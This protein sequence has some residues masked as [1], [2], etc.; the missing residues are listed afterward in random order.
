MGITRHRSLRAAALLLAAVCLPV[1]GADPDL[2]QSA[3][4]SLA[5]R[6]RCQMRMHEDAVEFQHC[7]DAL[8]SPAPAAMNRAQRYARLGTAYYA[9]LAATSAAKNGLPKAQDAALHFLAIFRPLQRQLGV[10]DEPLC[11]TIPGDCPSRIARLK[12]MEQQL[13]G[14]R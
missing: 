11:A 2:E 10:P 12:I 14:R 5:A 9:W 1:F 7:A 6:D 4:A 8:L 13:T 3:R